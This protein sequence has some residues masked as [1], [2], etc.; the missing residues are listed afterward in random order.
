MICVCH[1]KMRNSLNPLFKK[2]SKLY[3]NFD[4]LYLVDT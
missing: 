3:L 4:K 1:G 2:K